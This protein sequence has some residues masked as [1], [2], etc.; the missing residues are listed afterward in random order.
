MVFVDDDGQAYI[1]FGQGRCYIAKL[2][3]GHMISLNEASMVSY[4]PEGYKRSV[5]LI[6]EMV[7]LI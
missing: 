4:K 5:F 1:Y 7:I 6:K 2:N 3:P